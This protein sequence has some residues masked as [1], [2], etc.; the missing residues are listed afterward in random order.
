MTVKLL[1]VG[2][3]MVKRKDR[4]STVDRKTKTWLELDVFSG[5]F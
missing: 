4:K 2:G 1:G 3:R 5:L